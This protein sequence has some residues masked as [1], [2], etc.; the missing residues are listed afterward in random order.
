MPNADPNSKQTL[1]PT[2]TQWNSNLALNQPITK[3][4]NTNLKPQSILMAP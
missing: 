4:P 2:L 1:N 3:D